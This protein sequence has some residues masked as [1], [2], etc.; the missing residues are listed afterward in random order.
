MRDVEAASSRIPNRRSHA[1]HL[2]STSWRS[3]PVARAA[4]AVKAGETASSC[5]VDARRGRG[6]RRPR[7]SRCDGALGIDLRLRVAAL[8]RADRRAHDAAALVERR[9]G[10][11]QHELGVRRRAEVV[12]AELLERRAGARFSA[13]PSTF[14]NAVAASTRLASSALTASKPIVVAF[15][16]SG[17]PPSPVHDRA[18]HRVV[19]RQPG[20]A[21]AL[22]LEIARARRSPGCGEHRGQRPLDE[23]HHADDVAR[24]A[25]A[26]ARGR[27]CRGSPCRRARPASSFSA[28]VEAPGAPDRR[29][30]RPRPRRSRARSR[31]RCRRARRWA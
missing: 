29:G 9:A 21:G 22:A 19:G 18:Q 17:S 16:L 26:P 25:R 3:S 15:T 12:D 11:A 20:D 14:Q 1:A 2:R 10:D 4:P 13:T 31:G 30:R 28:S 27:G 8:Q 24:R 7:P 5:A 23:R 6:P